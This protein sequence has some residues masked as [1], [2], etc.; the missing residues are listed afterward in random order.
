MYHQHAYENY[1]VFSINYLRPLHRC[2]KCEQIKQI[3][4][5]H[6]NIFIAIPQQRQP[7]KH[8]KSVAV[9]KLR[10]HVFASP[11]HRNLA[12][13]LSL[14]EVINGARTWSLPGCGVC[15]S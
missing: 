11:K 12:A 15:D 4:T 9:F 10:T 8:D 13:R 14:Y 7:G 1:V 3:L 2:A 5:L 6:K